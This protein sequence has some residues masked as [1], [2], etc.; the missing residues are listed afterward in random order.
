[1]QRNFSTDSYRYPSELL[2]LAVTLF[3]VFLVIA[4]TAAATVCGSALFAVLAIGMAASASRAHHQALMERAIP[5]DSQRSPDLAR[6]AS[7]CQR[8]LQPGPVDIFVT[9]S[10][11]L[12]AYTFGLSDIK[13]VVLYSALLQVMD[14]DELRFIL[15][16]E[17]GHVRLGHTRLNSLVGGLAGIPSS[18]AASMLLGM[19]FLGWNR[20]CEYS[21]DRGLAG[22]GHPEKAFGA[23]QA[24]RRPQG[25]TQSGLEW[26]TGRSTPK[27]IPHGQPD[28]AW[29]RTPC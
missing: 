12:N 17:L 6:L 8:R 18:S 7:E 4:I 1:M 16:H 9:R 10:R 5:V 26:P 15:G 20:A 23:D 24:G 13:A 14:A 29:V 22:C 28:E 27:T 19:A 25:L 11:E 21:A 2:I 3:L